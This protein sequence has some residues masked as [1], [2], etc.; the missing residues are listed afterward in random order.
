MHLHPSTKSDNYLNLCLEQASL[1][2]LTFRH[3]SVIVKGGKVI[4]AGFNDYR[5]GFNGGTLKTGALNNSNTASS[6]NSGAAAALSMHSEMM[7]IHAALGNRA[8]AMRGTRPLLSNTSAKQSRMAVEEY[9]EA[10][11]RAAG[12]PP[13]HNRCGRPASMTEIAEGTG[14]YFEGASRG[15]ARSEARWEW[16]EEREE[17]GRWR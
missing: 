16:G 11:L 4:G 14:W 10:V 3:G 1:S 7:A 9:A 17:R 2:P 12:R 15:L 8:A 6:S 5:P 13:H